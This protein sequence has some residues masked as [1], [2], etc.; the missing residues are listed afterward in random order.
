MQKVDVYLETDSA[1]QG[2]TYRKCGYVLST[3]LRSGNEWTREYFGNYTGTY[4]QTV[5]RIIDEALSRMNF[6][7]E[8]CVHTQ[9]IYVASRIPKLE[10]MAKEGWRDGKGELIKNA[11]EWERIYPLHPCLSESAQNGCK[12]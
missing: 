8:I 5:L 6:P 11:A 7:V 12:I 4:H 3:I 9:D 2:K 1:Y 10:E